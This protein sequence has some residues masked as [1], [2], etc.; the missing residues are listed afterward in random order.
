MSDGVEESSLV[1]KMSLHLGILCTVIISAH[2]VR[3][4]LRRGVS[5]SVYVPSPSVVM[6]LI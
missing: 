5:P 6:S 1:I 4:V 3:I 2:V